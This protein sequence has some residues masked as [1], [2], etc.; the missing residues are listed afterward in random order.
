LVMIPEVILEEEA[1]AQ[2]PTP[3][4][5]RRIQKRERI[6]DLAKGY[7]AAGYEGCNLTRAHGTPRI[8]R[9]AR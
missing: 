6:R 3:N 2:R 7:P 5:Q 4:A 8:F 9:G 1:N